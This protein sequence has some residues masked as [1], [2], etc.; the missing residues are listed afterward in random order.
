MNKDW[1]KESARDTIALGS[2]PFLL[3]TIA[4][5]SVVANY[6]VMQFII[7]SALF[8]ILRKIFKAELHAGIGLILLAFTSIFYHHVLFTVFAL[9]V[10]AG[11]VVSLF[12]LDKNKIE[13]LKGVLFGT[14]SVAAT[15]LVVRL[16]FF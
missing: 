9:V 4:R 8:L 16:I 5:V 15:Y 2:I 7:S 3:L 12:I 11:M 1:I 10:Y 13:I 6:Y 14:V